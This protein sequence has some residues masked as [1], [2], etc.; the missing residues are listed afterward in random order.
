MLLSIEFF[1]LLYIYQVQSQLIGPHLT[2]EVI[3]YEKELLRCLPYDDNVMGV[4][5]FKDG[6][7]FQHRERRTFDIMNREKSYTTTCKK[8]LYEETLTGATCHPLN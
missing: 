8:R 1:I 5:F 7:L 6:I 4:K 3:S 2:L